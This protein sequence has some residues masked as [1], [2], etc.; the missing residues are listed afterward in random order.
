M[1]IKLTKLSVIWVLMVALLVMGLL[2]AALIHVKVD[3]LEGIAKSEGVPVHY[4]G[5][6]TILNHPAI[7]HEAIGLY[8]VKRNFIMVDERQRLNPRVLAHELGHY[9]SI[10]H[11]GDYSEEAAEEVCWGLVWQGQRYLEVFD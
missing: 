5:V 2:Y 4:V 9:Y 3:E 6:D 8:D 7:H 11:H 1:R 10:K